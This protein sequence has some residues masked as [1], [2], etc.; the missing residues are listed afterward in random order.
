MNITDQKNKI[1]IYSTDTCHFC[2]LVKDYLKEKGFS[3]EDINV[4]LDASQA[5]IMIEKSGQRGVPVI[6]IEGNIIIGFDQE[7]IDELLN[8]K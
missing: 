7:K 1:I 3:Y 2:H 5:K 8:I 4:G 6:D